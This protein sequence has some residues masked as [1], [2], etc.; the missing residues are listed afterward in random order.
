MA[1]TIG[2]SQLPAQELEPRSTPPLGLDVYS[3]RSPSMGNRYE[4]S[5]GVPAGARAATGKKFP[6]LVV[7]DANLALPAALYAARTLAGQDGI[8]GIFI[9][10]I[11]PPPEEDSF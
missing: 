5:I 9:I 2:S 6:A 1:L 3:F 7:T 4:I 11:G 10:G 8:G